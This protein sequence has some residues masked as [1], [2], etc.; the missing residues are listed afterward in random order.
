[1]GQEGE[2][3]ASSNDLI[4][5]QTVAVIPV[6][7][8][9][10][11]K[12]LNSRRRDRNY[13]INRHNRAVIAQKPP[14][15]DFL[16]PPRRPPTSPTQTRPPF[17]YDSRILSLCNK[18]NEKT[19]KNRAGVGSSIKNDDLKPIIVLHHNENKQRTGPYRFRSDT[20][21]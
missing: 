19:N 15:H 12:T 16:N 8:L 6:P 9:L 2:R 21:N 5:S 17:S 14:K 11:R 7:W 20:A 4:S 10:P 13:E 3:T 18:D 1:M